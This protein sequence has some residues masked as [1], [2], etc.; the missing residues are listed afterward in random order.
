MNCFYSLRQNLM[1]PLN[2]NFIAN[3]AAVNTRGK[4][5]KFY[6]RYLK[7]NNWIALNRLKVTRGGL[8]STVY[9]TVLKILSE[10][11]AAYALL[12]EILPVP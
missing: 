7:L 3:R 9:N 5:F 12:W 4:K 10:T 2:G 8:M 1:K 6:R 11:L